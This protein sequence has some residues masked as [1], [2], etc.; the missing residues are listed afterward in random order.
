M[1]LLS[2][3]HDNFIWHYTRAFKELFTVWVN[4]LWFVV[5]FFSIP[6]LVK[7]WF[8]PYKRI[9][10]QRHRRFDLEDIAGYI[11]INTLSRIVGAVMRTILIGL[12]LLFL[13]LMIAFGVVV[14]LLWIFLPIII[15]ATLVV[16][17]SILFTGV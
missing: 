13:T 7:S 16:G 14:Y 12:G 9:T 11:I 6:Q 3:T 5:H 15:L 4:I 2:V 17:V 1:L 10:E 8:A